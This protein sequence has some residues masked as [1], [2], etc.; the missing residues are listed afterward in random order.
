MI[1]FCSDNCKNIFQK[2]NTNKWYKKNYNFIKQRR[3][4]NLPRRR[5]M[6]RLRRQ[7]DLNYKIANVIRTRVACVLKG[8]YKSQHTLDLLSCTVDFLKRYLESKFKP[9]MTWENYGLYTWHIDHIKPCASFDLSDPEQ[10][11]QCFHY[12]N[13]QP[14]WATENLLKGRKIYSIYTYFNYFCK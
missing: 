10:Q 5:E 2:E 7:T 1:R 3:L 6:A 13:L 11:K 12:T 9:G 4:R 14:L 8:K